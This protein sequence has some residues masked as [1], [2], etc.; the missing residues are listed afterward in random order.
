[1]NNKSVDGWSFVY[2]LDERQ[3]FPQGAD[4]KNIPGVGE[5]YHQAAE[6]DKC[7]SNP[8]M[9]CAVSVE[10]SD[11]EELVIQSDMPALD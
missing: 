2:E 1:M 9:C 8:V 5:I 3:R 11:M 7:L 4:K 6:S 10:G